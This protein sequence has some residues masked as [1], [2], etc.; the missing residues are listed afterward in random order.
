VQRE[1]PD[2]V[3]CHRGRILGHGGHGPGRHHL[4]VD[5]INSRTLQNETDD[6]HNAT[7]WGVPYG[8]Y[9]AFLP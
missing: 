3:R 5:V 4:V 2:E 9:P 8:A 6:D 1:Q 7:A